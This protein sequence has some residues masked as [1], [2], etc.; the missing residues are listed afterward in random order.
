MPVRLSGA[1][2]HGALDAC[3]RRVEIGESSF[4]EVA[5]ELLLGEEHFGV[6]IASLAPK[7]AGAAR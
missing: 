7:V 4:H 5:Y 1:L 6:A 3:C 2:G